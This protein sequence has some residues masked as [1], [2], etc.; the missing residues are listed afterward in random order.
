M[1]RQENA[2]L[3]QSVIV[4]LE[5]QPVGCNGVLFKVIPRYVQADT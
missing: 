3:V 5:S 1:W 2:N 4:I